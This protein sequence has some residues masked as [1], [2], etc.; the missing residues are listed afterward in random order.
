[1]HVLDKHRAHMAAWFL[2]RSKVIQFPARE[3]ALLGTYCT[4]TV[5]QRMGLGKFA[6]AREVLR[7]LVDDRALRIRHEGER[8]APMVYIE[9]A[10][11][12]A[13]LAGHPSADT[14]PVKGALFELVQGTRPMAKHYGLTPDIHERLLFDF[15]MAGMAGTLLSN[16]AAYARLPEQ[17]GAVAPVSEEDD[18]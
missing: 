3:S 5:P 4:S 6:E 14:I 10:D 9:D 17:A 2:R 11:K 15:L 1:M 12:L 18:D 7:S 8:G 13:R 16:P